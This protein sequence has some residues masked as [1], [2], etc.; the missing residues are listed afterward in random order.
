LGFSVVCK[1]VE[2]AI[3]IDRLS[4]FVVLDFGAGTCDEPI[5]EPYGSWDLVDAA[6]SRVS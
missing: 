1:D 5:A 4:G 6:V 3:A 2:C